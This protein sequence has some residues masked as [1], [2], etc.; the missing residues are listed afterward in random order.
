MLLFHLIL[1]LIIATVFKM[2]IPQPPH[3]IIFSS[4]E[5]PQTLTGYDEN[6]I[7]Y[8]LKNNEDEKEDEKQYEEDGGQYEEDWGQYEEDWEDEEYDPAN[9]ARVLSEYCGIELTESDKQMCKDVYAMFTGSEN[10]TK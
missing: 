2:N 8:I 9:V 10:E 1:F 4:S 6:G 5:M 3:L 7:P